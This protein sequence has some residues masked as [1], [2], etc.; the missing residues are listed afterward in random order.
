MAACKALVA[1]CNTNNPCL[2][3]GY[4]AKLD[5]QKV[6]EADELFEHMC[7][8]GWLWQTVPAW[9]DAKF[10][11]FA[12]IA[13]KA[14]NVQKE[15]LGTDMNDLECGITM[16]ELKHDHFKEPSILHHVKELNIPCSPYADAIMLFAEQYGWHEFSRLR[17]VDNVC[18]LREEHEQLERESWWDLLHMRFDDTDTP[19][20]FIRVALLLVFSIT[21]RRELP[22]W[23]KGL[24]RKWSSIDLKQYEQTL[25]QIWSLWMRNSTKNLESSDV[26]TY[27]NEPGLKAV[28][29]AFLTVGLQ[30]IYG[31]HLPEEH[32]D[33]PC[34]IP[35]I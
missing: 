20:V 31:D 9:V 22:C 30:V 10:P 8:K 17:F 7:T 13:Q 11:T 28:G 6:F 16:M 33:L 21:D 29:D 32:K 34:T 12:R 3:S 15:G 35:G 14:L 5:A 26:L 27:M 19:F 25:T 23:W 2:A 18:K 1:G 4:G 24:L